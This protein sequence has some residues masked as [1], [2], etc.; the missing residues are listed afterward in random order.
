[1]KRF[2]VFVGHTYYPNGGWEDF[3]GERDTLAEARDIVRVTLAEDGLGSPCD[4]AHVVDAVT[5]AKV[6]DLEEDGPP[7]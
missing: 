3:K 4:W 5:S 2:L 7:R 6:Y 1:M